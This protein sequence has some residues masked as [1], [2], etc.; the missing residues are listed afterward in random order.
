M[1]GA[2][3]PGPRSDAFASRDQPES[4]FAHIL[5][6]FVMGVPGARAA[7]L[8]DSDGETIDYA[9]RI[10]PFALRL[11]AA[12]W[13]IVFD[14]AAAGTSVGQVAFVAVCTEQASYLVHAL[15]EGHALVVVLANN[16]DPNWRRPLQVCA[17][18][19]AEE[20][21]WSANG[22]N[23]P[24]R[25]FPLAIV[26]DGEKRPA[27]IRVAGVARPLEI[28]GTVVGGNDRGEAAWRVRFD[29]G[30]EATLVR[31]SSGGWHADAPLGALPTDR[32]CL[33]S[34][35]E[36]LQK[37]LAWTVKRVDHKER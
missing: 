3:Q 24:E 2:G 17:R 12:Q 27:A 29:T 23:D 15:R 21:G 11:A 28:I 33:A 6:A 4:A 8:V 18:A 7:A 37:A 26:S 16:V 22:T 25:T 36:G 19:L 30:M 35:V 31:E 34:S 32:R 5:S 9:G 10:D 14:Q 1:T 13:R 20:A